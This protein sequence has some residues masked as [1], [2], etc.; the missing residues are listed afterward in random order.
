M[1]GAMS[2]LLTIPLLL[3]GVAAPH[4][5]AHDGRSTAPDHA[6]RPHVH[7]TG[8]VHSHGGA[9]PNAPHGRPHRH[10]HGAAK[11]PHHAADALPT[12]DLSPVLA[13]HD[14]D[15]VYVG[16][17]AMV[18]SGDRAVAPPPAK[19]A[20]RASLLGDQ[21]PGLTRR[22]MRRLAAGPPGGD[23]ASP[24]ELLPHLLRI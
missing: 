10:Q 24:F 19:V 4:T 14:H 2:V 5:H 22:C 20:W 6:H 15:A 17:G 16:S 7:L 18:V 23:S 1:R 3:R 11:R 8:L 9:Q 13:D 12:P 21:R